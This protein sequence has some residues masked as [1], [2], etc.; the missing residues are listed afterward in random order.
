MDIIKNDILKLFDNDANINISK[1]DNLNN[2]T[3]NIYTIKN[4]DTNY[5][6]KIYDID[7][8]D[9]RKYMGDNEFYFYT[10]FIKYVKNI[11]KVPIF[12]GLVNNNNN[13]PYGLILEKLNFTKNIDTDID[14][15]ID[16]N[17][18]TDIDTNI[19]TDINTNI[20]TDIDTNIDTNIDTDIDTNIDT[21]IDTDIDT[22]YNI[23]DHISKLHIFYWNKNIDNILNYKNNSKFIINEKIK[24]DIRHYF[25]NIKNI[26]DD[27]L[28][29]IFNRL[30]NKNDECGLLNKNNENCKNKTLIHGSLKIDNIII[31]NDIPYFIDWSLYNSGYGVEDILFLIIFSLDHEKLLLNYENILNYYLIEIN[32]FYKYSLNSL[33]EDIIKSLEDFIANAII[34]LCIKNHFAKI[35]NNK[36]D[37]YLKNFLFLLRQFS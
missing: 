26:F 9:T 4:N 13:E 30:L 22:I 14:T 31:V 12:Y 35:K 1:I 10:K 37:I 5:I 33:T 36:I 11:I 21:D 15:D 16:T 23:I 3:S 8:I 19:D 34:G 24:Y 28:Y 18:D 17:I 2:N 27:E 20:D 29:N 32:K 6:C 7:K 25:Y